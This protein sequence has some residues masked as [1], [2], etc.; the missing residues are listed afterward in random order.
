[1]ALAFAAMSILMRGWGVS[2]TGSV[3]ATL[4]YAFGG[5]V[6]LQYCNVI[7]LVGAAWMPLAFYFADRWLHIG[8]RRALA[9]LGLVLTMQTLGGDPEVAYLSAFAAAICALGVTLTAAG[10]RR[11]QR[12]ATVVLTLVDCLSGPSRLAAMG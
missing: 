4:A 1:M 6:L 3:L 11:S 8:D 10:K 12:L 2:P 9:W 7:F 5:P